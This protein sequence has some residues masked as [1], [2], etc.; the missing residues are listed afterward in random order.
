MLETE[1]LSIKSTRDA[2]IQLVDADAIDFDAYMKNLYD[3]ASVLR[4]AVRKTK[5]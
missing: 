4:K 1:R 3:A 5:K 2:A